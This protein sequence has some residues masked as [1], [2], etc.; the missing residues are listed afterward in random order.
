MLPNS[1]RA[2]YILFL[3]G[4]QINNPILINPEKAALQHCKDPVKAAN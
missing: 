4:F 2:F 1:Q 3:I